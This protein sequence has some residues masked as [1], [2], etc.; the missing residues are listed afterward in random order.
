VTQFLDLV[1]SQRLV[2]HDEGMSVQSISHSTVP[3][4]GA[5]CSGNFS[6][7]IKD[8]KCAKKYS[9]SDSDG[10]REAGGSGRLSRGQKHSAEDT[11]LWPRQQQGNHAEIKQKEEMQQRSLKEQSKRIINFEVLRD[12]GESEEAVFGSECKAKQDPVYKFGIFQHDEGWIPETCEETHKVAEVS[13]C[14]QQQLVRKI[15]QV[16]ETMNLQYMLQKLK[17]HVERTEEVVA[18]L[19]C[20]ECEQTRYGSQNADISSETSRLQYRQ[21]PSEASANVI[22]RQCEIQESELKRH[23]QEVNGNCAVESFDCCNQQNCR[24]WAVNGHSSSPSVLD[25]V[26]KHQNELQELHIQRQT[27]KTEFRECTSKSTSCQSVRCKMSGK[28]CV[29]RFKQGTPLVR[30]IGECNESA[31]CYCSTVS[32]IA[33]ETN[34]GNSSSVQEAVLRFESRAGEHHHQQM[35]TVCERCDFEPSKAVIQSLGTDED[36]KSVFSQVQI[37]DRNSPS[38]CLCRLCVLDEEVLKFGNKISVQVPR[39]VTTH[40]RS[41]CNS[42][43]GVH[44]CNKNGCHCNVSLRSVCDRHSNGQQRHQSFHHRMHIPN[45]DHDDREQYVNH[46]CDLDQ[47]VLCTSPVSGHMLPKCHIGHQLEPEERISRS[48]IPLGDPTQTARELNTPVCQQCD[49]EKDIVETV[50]P[51]GNKEWVKCQ[52]A[53]RCQVC[54]LQIQKTVPE[55]DRVSTCQQ[56]AANKVGRECSVQTRD[57]RTS[58]D[59]SRNKKKRA[60]ALWQRLLRKHVTYSR[61]GGSRRKLMSVAVVQPS[62]SPSRS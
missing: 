22:Y 42:L 6:N 16:P 52:D 50:T 44:I 49:V 20:Q 24:H 54:E 57:Q 34:V 37:S 36:I 10:V 56:C 26:L 4:D 15:G 46:I 55:M 21:M 61:S 1:T 41:Q 48:G 27:L 35:L 2:I 11:V 25:N 47:R 30:R 39:T 51:K 18:V 32:R 53:L 3:D 12:V 60:V 33:S 8:Q 31:A 7:L 62:S 28:C 58:D 29:N 38:V 17:Q 14:V 23:V 5:E 45:T 40:S 19:N 43:S 9:L 13:R 59:G